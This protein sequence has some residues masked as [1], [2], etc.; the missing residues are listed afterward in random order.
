M[1]VSVIHDLNKEA[2][3]STSNSSEEFVGSNEF[4][5]DFLKLS[6]EEQD[7]LLK[8][9]RTP[10][11]IAQ[12]NRVKESCDELHVL[13]EKNLNKITKFKERVDGEAV[14]TV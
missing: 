7:R 13:L 1:V 4:A 6:E 8:G 3:M 11:T 10:E 2:C 12:L 9:S 5:E 14:A